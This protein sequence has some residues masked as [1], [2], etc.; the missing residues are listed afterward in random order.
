M[1]IDFFCLNNKYSTTQLVTQNLII[2]E[3]ENYT[4]A[5]KKSYLPVTQQKK[6]AGGLRTQ[7]IYKKSHYEK[8]LISIITVVFNGEEYIEQ[9]IES[10]LNQTYNN[11]E[12]II[13]D[14]DSIDETLTI[15]KK[16]ENGIDYWLSEKDTGIYNAMNKAIQLS[17]GEFT[18]FIN[19]DDWYETDSI[20]SVIDF[21]LKYPSD[22]CFFGDV[23]IIVD[24][25]VDSVFSERLASYKYHMPVPHP[26]LFVR[27]SL[28]MQMGFDERYKIIADYDLV[29]K[30]IKKSY[31][32]Q[33][34]NKIISN[35][36]HGGISTTLSHRGEHFYLLHCHFGL[37]FALYHHIINNYKYDLFFPVRLT[38][39]LLK[40]NRKI[41]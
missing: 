18:A 34:V 24:G 28:L 38:K 13:I 17:T 1:Q 26:G 35:H 31:I 37:V 39:K 10:V 41:L 22:S 32:F 33:N 21:I 40:I 9:T 29:I 27:T 6:V 11:I 15:I 20:Q 16:Y 2:V 36:R 19:A 12:Y 7:G 4:D 3:Q 30:L 23:N 25:K 8:P 5:V 14:A